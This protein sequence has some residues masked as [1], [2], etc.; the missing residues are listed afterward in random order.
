MESNTDSQKTSLLNNNNN[1]NNSENNDLDMNPEVVTMILKN[2][3]KF[4]KNK[5]YLEKDMNLTRLSALLNTNSKYAG[6]VI[7]KYRG[8]KTID[9]ISDLKLKHIINLLK[10]ENKYRLYTNEALGEE[11]GFS[12]TQNF[13]RAFKKQTKISPTYFIQQLQ[14]PIQ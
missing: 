8:Q 3:E 6:K 4:E 1:N 9:Y 11:A 12:S 2:L 14:K 5:K 13:T 7:S 10:N